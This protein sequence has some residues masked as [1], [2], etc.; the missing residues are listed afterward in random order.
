[1]LTV[2]TAA[3]LT[4]GSIIMQ[5]LGVVP[6]LVQCRDWDRLLTVLI[7]GVEALRHTEYG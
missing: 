4:M 2:P 5:K 1:M 7:Q 6:G 3:A